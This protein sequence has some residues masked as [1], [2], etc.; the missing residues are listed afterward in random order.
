MSMAAGSPLTDGSHH[1]G[2][3]WV[4]ARSKRERV[5]N[6]TTQSVAYAHD[7]TPLTGC[8]VWDDSLRDRRPG[9]F[10]V[11]GGAGLDDHARDRARRLAALGYVAFAGDM[12]GDGVA[13]SRERI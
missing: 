12:Y 8:L 10:V 5:V 6:L 7:G 13:G 1:Q 4:A 3:E 9:I 11:H 2:C